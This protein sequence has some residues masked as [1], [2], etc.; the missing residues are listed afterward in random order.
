VNKHPKLP[1]PLAPDCLKGKVILLLGATGTLGQAVAKT[2]CQHQAEVIL[3]ARHIKKLEKL[4]DEL[5]VGD[6]EPAIQPINLMNIGLKEMDE[7]RHHIDSLYGRLDGII[8]CSGKWG[9][10]TPIE[11]YKESDWLELMHLNLN[12]PFLVTKHLLPLLKKTKDSTVIF[13]ESPL[14]FE[15]KAYHGAFGASQL[16]LHGLMQTLHHE[17]NFGSMRFMGINVECL[18]SETRRKLYPADPNPE[19]GYEPTAVA[20]IYAALLTEFGEK[21]KGQCLQANDYKESFHA[22]TDPESIPSEG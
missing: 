16:A 7:L 21:F 2:L 18:Q 17:H 15:S 13:T 10:L 11:H 3:S 6:V 5:A 12:A 20:P 8:F 19:S 22:S 9:E 1:L 4:Y 14:S